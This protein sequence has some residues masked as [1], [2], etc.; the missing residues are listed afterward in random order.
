MTGSKRFINGLKVGETSLGNILSFTS[1]LS[2]EQ[3]QNL[4]GET[5]NHPCLWSYR[6]FFLNCISGK[7]RENLQEKSSVCQV[8]HS[9]KRMGLVIS[10]QPGGLGRG[11]SVSHCCWEHFFTEQLK[12]CPLL[13]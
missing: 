4:F 10:F 5:P 8:R 11:G 7:T 1:L 3:T 12:I 2:C 6:L 9:S 13:D